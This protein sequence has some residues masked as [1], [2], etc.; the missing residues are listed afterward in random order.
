MEW[1]VGLIQW[2]QT[3][4]SSAGGL[5]GLFSF[6]GSE[7]G[8]LLIV[9]TVMFCWRKKAGQKLLL[10]VSALNMWLPMIKSIVLRP[11]PYT[12]H[13]DRIKALTLKETEARDVVTQGYSFPSMHSASVPALY[14]T[15]AKEV[16]KKWLW[17]LAAVLT[18]L[19]GV[20]RFVVGEHYPTDVLAGWILG[21]AAIG[22]FA[23]MD[24][25]V[26]NEWLYYLILLVSALPGLFYIRTN[27][28]YTSLGCL[29]GAAVTIPFERRFVDFQD[30]RKI[31]VMILRLT[32][33]L[34]SYFII[35]SLLKIPFD[36]QFLAGA[37]LAA[38]LVRTARYAINIF[39]VM[40]V[41]PKIFP[42]FER[43]GKK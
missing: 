40:G 36:K 21:F 25:Y 15:L 41:Y 29:I 37:S 38:L 39:L 32:G 1:E 27:D 6:I 12:E 9:M 42:L 18:V 19:V 17:I 26:H 10:I 22:V 14:F 20:S 4:L 43:V 24:R 13:P 16:K 31:P 34:L 7:T 8:L 35:N 3:N 23:L 2:I 30:T 28:F 33:A 5:A 11:R